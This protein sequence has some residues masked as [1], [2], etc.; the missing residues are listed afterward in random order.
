MIT[1][2]LDHVISTDSFG[3]GG[4]S[5]EV[6]ERRYVLPKVVA[7]AGIRVG[8]ARDISGGGGDIGYVS[9]GPATS[10]EVFDLGMIEGTIPA[11][12]PAGSWSM[13]MKR[14]TGSSP[15]ATRPSSGSSTAPP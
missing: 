3:F 15:S 10:G 4:L 7:A 5:P 8:S 1:F 12:T 11:L 2:P 14:A 9:L 6:S 13:T